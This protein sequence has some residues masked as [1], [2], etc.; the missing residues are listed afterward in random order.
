MSGEKLRV[1]K[2]RVVDWNMQVYQEYNYVP[3]RPTI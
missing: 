1:L 3:Q 2:G